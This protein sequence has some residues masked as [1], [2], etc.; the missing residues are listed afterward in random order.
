LLSPRCRGSYLLKVAQVE[1]LEKGELYFPYTPRVR[2]GDALPL[3]ARR[4]VDPAA[5]RAAPVHRPAADGEGGLQADPRRSQADAGSAAKPRL[6]RR[7]PDVAAP[8]SALR[9][10]FGDNRFAPLDPDLLDL[11]GLELV[12]IGTSGTAGQET[13]IEP[14]R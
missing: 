10:K 12:L 7:P 5:G 4:C 1:L 9:E 3:H 14:R 13:G 11:E 6:G 8:P 2:P